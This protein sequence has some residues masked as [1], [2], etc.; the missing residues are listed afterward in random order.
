LGEAHAGHG[1][2]ATVVGMAPYDRTAV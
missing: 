2:G 1:T